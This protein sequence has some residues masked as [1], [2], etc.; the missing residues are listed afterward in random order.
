MTIVP[1]APLVA[2]CV[3]PWLAAGAVAAE[4]ASTPAP[5]PL[6]IESFRPSLV[7]GRVKEFD[8]PNIVISPAK[9]SATTPLVVFLPATSGKPADSI[10]LL[11]VV[12]GQGYPVIGLEYNSFPP[13][14]RFCQEST[15][16]D[17]FAAFREMRST[18]GGRNAP[19]ANSEAE[20]I[21][22]RLVAMLAYLARTRPEGG[23]SG[24]LEGDQPRWDRLVLSGLSQGA[25]MAAYLAKR[26]VVSR[27]VL[28]S[29]PW[30]Y[31]GPNREPAPWLSTPSATPMA[32][33]HAEYNSREAT[34]E[35]LKASYARLRIPAAN[36][37]VFSRDLPADAR[38]STQVN[39]YHYVTV[40]DT[41]YADEWRTMFGTPGK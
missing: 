26:H 14:V 41:A 19:V 22:R 2:I 30:D 1:T 40:T 11:K 35:A 3:A 36:I 18:G 39:P 25:G 27:V 32:S 15:D 20:S 37:R 13:G 10:A 23:W 33:W 12:A 28:F 31:T 16:L 8:E 38:R 5:P 7:D 4:A 9:P 17:C 21:V 29:S 6:R 34:A 24:Y